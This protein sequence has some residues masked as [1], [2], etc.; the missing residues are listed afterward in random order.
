PTPQLTA[1]SYC[2]GTVFGLRI[3]NKLSV[4]QLPMLL[5]WHV[6]IRTAKSSG[7]NISITKLPLRENLMK[8]PEGGAEETA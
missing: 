2:V 4:H 7:V 6:F 3:R 1:T 8:I 5:P